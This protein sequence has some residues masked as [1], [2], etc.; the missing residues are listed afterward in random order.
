MYGTLLNFLLYGTVLVALVGVYALLKLGLSAIRRQ[1]P[2][3]QEFMLT[4]L[5]V[6]AMIYLAGNLPGS[7]FLI[8]LKLTE[9]LFGEAVFL[10]D[11]IREEGRSSQDLNGNYTKFQLYHLEAEKMKQIEAAIAKNPNFPDEDKPS[12]W[13]KI[14]WHRLV[15]PQDAKAFHPILTLANDW[16]GSFHLQQRIEKNLQAGKHIYLSGF[17]KKPTDIEL[18]LVFPEQKELIQIDIDT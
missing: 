10:P 11:P 17:Y 5:G 16:A 3:R 8:R 4:G 14:T 18:Y 9:R 12:T 6:L 2:T 13:Q 15:T 1:K 7:A